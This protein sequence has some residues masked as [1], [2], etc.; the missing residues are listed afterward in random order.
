MHRTPQGRAV[1]RLSM[2]LD[3][4]SPVLRSSG[5]KVCRVLRQLQ[6]HCRAHSLNLRRLCDVSQS[7][8]V[9]VRN[10][11]E[12]LQ[13]CNVYYIDQ[14]ERQFW[15]NEEIDQVMRHF[16]KYGEGEVSM[17]EVELA[18]A[19]SI[20]GQKDTQPWAKFTDG[21]SAVAQ[22]LDSKDATFLSPSSS[23]GRR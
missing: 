12:V 4:S 6:K 13:M 5:K 18:L 14:G 16:D 10:L 9:S 7:G 3:N 15:G 2:M 20:V 1:C 11:S 22:G 8:A 21:G 23:F 17:N 19:R